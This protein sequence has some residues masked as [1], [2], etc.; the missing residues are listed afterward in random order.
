MQPLACCP[1]HITGKGMLKKIKEL[2]P[3]ANIVAVVYDPGAS[4]VEPDQPHP[5][6]MLERQMSLYHFDFPICRFMLCAAS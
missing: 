3:E 2:H 6:L 4:H 1:N 5:R